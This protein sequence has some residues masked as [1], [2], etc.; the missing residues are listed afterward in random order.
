MPPKRQQ[1]QSK[2]PTKRLKTATAQAEEVS[3][4]VNNVQTDYNK[5]A[6]AMMDISKQQ[7]DN[8]YIEAE[9]TTSGNQ[10]PTTGD[11]ASTSQR[12]VPAPTSS[13]GEILDQVFL[14]DQSSHKDFSPLND[15]EVPFGECTICLEKPM[16]CVILDCCHLYCCCG[17]A[18]QL[19]ECFT[20]RGKLSKVVRIFKA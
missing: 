5:L 9:A 20:C 17:C 10:T 1:R 19:K 2:N 3:T 14:G 16:D 6:Q 11:T 4:P 7:P 13:L 15:L 12:S 18:K 8:L